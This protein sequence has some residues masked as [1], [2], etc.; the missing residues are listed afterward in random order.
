MNKHFIIVLILMPVLFCAGQIKAQQTAAYQD[1][2]AIYNTGISLFNQEQYGA[3][4]KAFEKVIHEDQELP[5]LMTV[6][7]GYYAAVCALELEHENGEYKL[8]NFIREHPENT[9]VK[10]AYFQLGKYQFS[11]G[12]YTQALK[13]FTEVEVPD[14]D[15]EERTEYYYKKGYS[16]YKTQKPDRARTSFRK[17]LNS[18]S[19]YTPYATYYYAVISFE[20][21]DDDDAKENFEK[22]IDNR[23]FRKSVRN[24]LAHIYHRE[25]EYEKMME[26]AIPAY[27]EASGKDKPGLALMIGDAL[28]QSGDYDEALPYFEFYERSSRRSM[29]R[30]EAYEIGYTLFMKENYKAAIQNFQQAVGEDD[31]LAQNAYYHLG[32]CYLQ[33]D[34]KKFASNAFSSACKMDFDRDI[35]EDAL[36]NY[37]K[38]SMEVASDPYNTAIASLEDYI[39]RYPGSPRVDE[40]YSFLASLYLSTKN[41]KQ[42]LTS[43]EKIKSQNPA[44]K[45]AYQKICFYRGIELFNANELDKAVPLFKKAA[46]ENYDKAIAAEANLWIGEAFYRQDNSWGAI[47]Y[48]KEFLNSPGAKQLEVFSTAYYNLGYVY[49]NKKDYG[50]AIT[51]F[52]KFADYKGAKD[53]RLVTDALVRLGDCYFIRKDYNKAIRNYNNAIR[54]GSGKTDYALYQKAITQGASGLFNDKVRTLKELISSQ[55][56]S[57]YAD[58][59]KYELAGTYLLLNKNTDALSWFNKLIKDHPNSRFAI[60]SLLKTGLIYYNENQNEKALTTLEKVVADNPGTP[61][62]RE[63]LNSIRNIYIDQNRVDEYYAYAGNL[64]FADVTVSEQDSITYIAAENLYME[65]NCEEAI[66]AF[67]AYLNSFPYGT[68]AVNASY[69]KAECEL[70][71]GMREEALADFAFVVSQPTSGFTENS[72]LQAA[73]LSMKMEAWDKALDYYTRLS[74]FAEYKDN[75]LEALEGR[76][77]C[78][79]KLGRW[80]NAITTSM[81]MLSNENVDDHR[82]HKAHY[83]MSKS[84]MAMDNLENARV[85]FAITEKL[86]KNEWG[87]ESKYMIAY[88]D[89]I[90]GKYTEAENGIFELGDQYASHDYWVA[91]GFLLLSDVY[92]ADGNEFQAKETLKSII[93]NYR[94]PDLGEIAAQKLAG[95]ESRT[96]DDL[97]AEAGD[98]L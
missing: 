36:F 33:T 7:A 27:N 43:V 21:G 62:S 37:A 22:L 16:Q 41:Y 12:K 77:D 82:I 13:S 80:A 18:K 44:L 84:Y 90:T 76:T 34:Q 24:Y 38:L 25:G 71:N 53:T 32:Y 10:R 23:S 6:N 31:Q 8:I 63:A 70:K 51:W 48:Y 28:Y 19:K 2:E 83:I 40:A 46:V 45:E 91:K 50:N 17:V 26:L 97:P 98:T 42:A 75:A 93:E 1:P 88:I 29:S 56:R 35:N 86:S 67:G 52:R 94:G 72:L 15:R 65:N 66:P 85:E 14:L 49:F 3:A 39:E 69:Y 89:F 92:L 95:I 74:D 96:G 59:A 47:K 11:N 5:G 78:N 73:R 55:G 61:E 68:F 79:Y 58:D 9:L 87:A 4:A 60:K 64:S 20:E 54:A 81:M 57:T 30:E